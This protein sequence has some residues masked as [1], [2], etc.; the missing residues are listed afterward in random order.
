VLSVLMLHHVV[1]WEQALAEAV[2]VLRPGGRI[3]AADLL[4]NAP[5]RQAEVSVELAIYPW[6]LQLCCCCRVQSKLATS[7]AAIGCVRAC[8]PLAVRSYVSNPYRPHSR[9]ASVPVPRDSSWKR[10]WLRA[11]SPGWSFRRNRAGLLG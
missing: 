10:C 9:S 11:W 8:C 3:V 6:T 5:L 7:P 1:A 2:R 4:A